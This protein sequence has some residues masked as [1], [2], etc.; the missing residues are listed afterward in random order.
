MLRR[1]DC[2]LLL[3]RRFAATVKSPYGDDAWPDAIASE[4]V[5]Y[6]GSL[7][8]AAWLGIEA[9]RLALPASHDAVLAVLDGA[10][11]NL[12][13]DMDDRLADERIDAFTRRFRSA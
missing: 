3:G 12:A 5:D 1:I 2:A 8:G 7:I 4:L 13:A 9:A 6:D 10:R 11:A